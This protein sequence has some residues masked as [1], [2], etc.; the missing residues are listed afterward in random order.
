MQIML[1]EGKVPQIHCG[2][3]KASNFL[4]MEII[5]NNQNKTISDPSLHSL[6]QTELGEKTKGVAVAVNET[7][8][9]KINWENTLLKEKDSVLIIKATQGG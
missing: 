2:I 1:P 6:I 9:P 4:E 8:I 7:V 3:S 5:L